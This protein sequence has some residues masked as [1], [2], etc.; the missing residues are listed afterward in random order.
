QLI[1]APHAIDNDRFAADRNQEALE[2]RQKFNIA[3]NEILILF[4]GKLE[5]K[6]NPELLLQAFI[7]LDLQ[8]T[9]LLFVGNGELEEILK[10]KKTLLQAQDDI[11]KRIHS[12]GFQ[13]QTQMPVV[14]QACD[15]FVLPSQGPGE[16]WGLAVNEAMAC[17]KAILVSDKVGCAADLVQVGINGEIF[18]ANNVNDL[19]K[20]LLNLLKY[21]AKLIEMGQNSKKLIQSWSFEIQAKE[22]L[23]LLHETC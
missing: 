21:K 3:T 2:L 8:N 18:Q 15:L 19:K 17:G 10:A 9:H 14:Y 12:M 20:K 4:T 13:N 6:K 5:K 16:T 11:H 1:F 23:T 22:I 7:Q